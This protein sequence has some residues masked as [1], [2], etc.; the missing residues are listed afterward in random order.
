MAFLHRKTNITDRSVY[1]FYL[2]VGKKCYVND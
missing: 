1:K 2:P